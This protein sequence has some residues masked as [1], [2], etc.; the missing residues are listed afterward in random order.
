MSVSKLTNYC[1]DVYAHCVVTGAAQQ[2]IRHKAEHVQDFEQQRT[3][4]CMFV[5]MLLFSTGALPTSN[6]KHTKQ[7]P[8]IKKKCSGSLAQRPIRNPK[9]PKEML[10]KLL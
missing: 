2:R 3:F 6:Q 7:R 1:W 10:L 4:Y 5:V 8:N 9:S